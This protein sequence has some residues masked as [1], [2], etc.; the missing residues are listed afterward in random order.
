AM[1]ASPPKADIAGQTSPCP[2]CARSGHARSSDFVKAAASRNEAVSNAKVLDCAM[3]LDG[4]DTFPVCLDA[5]RNF[6]FASR[7]TWL[8]AQ[9]DGGQR[10]HDAFDQRLTCAAERLDATTDH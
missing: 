7:A 3:V 1:S 9:T 8:D 2:L 5:A 10:H 4:S 6:N